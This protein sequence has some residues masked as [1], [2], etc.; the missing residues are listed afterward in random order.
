MSK[1]KTSV[2]SLRDATRSRANFSGHGGA[3][4]AAG[5]RAEGQRTAVSEFLSHSGETAI[6]NPPAKGFGK[7]RIGAAWDM[8]QVPDTSFLGKMV[9]RVK[10]VNVDLDLGCL[11]ELQDG[12]RGAIQALGDLYGS[13][14]QPPFIKLSGDE[15]EGDEEGDDEYILINGA[16][17][18]KIKRIVFYIYIYDGMPHW[19]SIKPQIHINVPG[20][21]SFAV[22]PTEADSDLAVCA[23]GGIEN[24]RGGI[25]MT[26]YT[27]FFPGHAEMDRAFGFGLQWADGAKAG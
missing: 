17:W 13:L 8:A 22:V 1:D 20:E 2:D 14:D 23:V 19:G 4:G 5:K 25:R 10:T 15:R 12:E 7:M 3:K 16:E 9:K 11:Y 6:I 27:E 21:D 24:V 18:S 26:N